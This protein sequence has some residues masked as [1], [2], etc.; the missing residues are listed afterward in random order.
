MLDNNLQFHIILEERNVGK[1]NC[2]LQIRGKANFQT[3]SRKVVINNLKHL[4]QEAPGSTF[5]AFRKQSKYIQKLK[6]EWNEKMKEFQ[7][8]WYSEKALANTNKRV[9]NWVILVSSWKNHNGPFTFKEEVSLFLENEIDVKT[10]RKGYTRKFAMRS[11][12]QR[13]CQLYQLCF[14]YDLEGSI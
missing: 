2:E 4:L 1:I 12:P 10:K 3:A 13:T 7:K 5:K 11:Y 8:K 9:W 14:A 6:V